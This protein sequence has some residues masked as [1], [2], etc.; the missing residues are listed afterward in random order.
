M[1][2][3]ATRHPKR[4]RGA[5]A[6]RGFRSAAEMREV[7]DRALAAV[8]EDERAGSLL[9]ATGMRLRVECPD[10]GGLIQVAASDDPDSFIEWRFDRRARWKPKLTL[11]M[12]SDVAN[13][14]LQG[15]ESVP[16]AIA[17]RRMTFSGEARS[18]LL[19]LP[20]VKLISVPY[21]RV[22]SS[23]FPHLAL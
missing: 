15:R 2:A 21:R 17:H 12:D 4:T 1:A 3:T 7:L 9:Q 11:T 22:V 14:W 6:G 18:A 8:N 13:E 10:V 23:A 19:Y 16:M 20:A 5:R